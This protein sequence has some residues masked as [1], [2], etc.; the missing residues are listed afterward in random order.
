ML[1]LKTILVCDHLSCIKCR[2][3]FCQLI[4]VKYSLFVRIVMKPCFTI[5]S[6]LYRTGS[7]INKNRSSGI[8]LNRIFIIRIGAY[9]V[10][11]IVVINLVSARIPVCRC[12]RSVSR[13]IE[14]VV[15]NR[16][17]PIVGM[18]GAPD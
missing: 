16:H 15:L 6:R 7:R 14:D 13:E 10:V 8:H 11:Q 1:K 5:L 4:S 12:N 17:R 2:R 3:I 9:I 18:H